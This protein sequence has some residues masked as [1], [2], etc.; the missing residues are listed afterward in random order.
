M[1][2][3]P[4]CS[5]RINGRLLSQAALADIRS[6]SVSD[7]LA[8]ASM[9]T[10]E[11][12]NWD[13]RA[14]R[15]TWSDDPLLA[16]GGEVDIRLGYA[17]QLQRVILGEITGLEPAFQSDSLPTLTVRGYD[18]RHRL[19]RGR[20]TRS[21]T[22]TKDSSIAR[23]IAGAAGLE[24]RVTDTKISLE[25]VLQRNQT[26]MA[27]LQERAR[28][29]GYEVFVRDK[30]LFFRPP[31]IDG[32]EVTTLS[33]DSDIVE[34]YPRLSAVAQVSEVEVRGW[35][36]KQ[37]QR[38]VAQAA[39]GA[40][41][42]MREA[43]RSGPRA[44]RVAFGQAVLAETDRPPF[45]KAEAAAMATGR[46]NQIALGYISAE[47]RC[48]GRAE[49]RAGTLVMI[50]GAGKTFSGRYYLTSVSHSYDPNDGFFTEFTCRRN[51]T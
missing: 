5:V 7:D 18:H 47:G 29:I 10:I 39:A 16:L 19:M 26:D 49:L 22:K 6:I 2:D 24:A 12:S 45:D 20:K 38:F 46:L 17:G 51:A 4:D 28:R 8:V 15:L 23:L 32:A 1:P 21:F 48:F 34:L 9:F 33:L 3:M 31:P 50:A 37:K 35:D 27:F 36:V 41:T 30:Q 40:E 13:E 14:L 11:L 43:G 25:Y 44:A 42:Q